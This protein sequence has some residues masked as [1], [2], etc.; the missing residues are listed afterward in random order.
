M[1]SR[2]REASELLEISGLSKR[3]GRQIVL[4]GVELRI[5]H[6]E[7][8]AVMGPS[9]SG[10]ST[11]LTCLAGLEEPDAGTI[12]FMGENLSELSEEQRA[13][14]RRASITS[15]FQFFHLLPTLRAAE[16]VEFPLLL[17]GDEPG[18]RRQ[19]VHSLLEEIGLMERA[20]AWPSE[21]SGGEMQR[22]A[23]ARALVTEPAIILA[24]EPTGSLDSKNSD[25]VLELLKRLT[26]A[27]QTA[28]L[29]VTHDKNAANICERIFE[30]R[31]GQLYPLVDEAL[32][33]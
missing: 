24:D 4:S 25:R 15:I 29:M 13:A 32:T 30:M 17:R 9:G 2:R 26:S 8:V 31:D 23:I 16:N 1:E 10:K 20:H 22:L 18:A 11:L 27:H 28:L 12:R 19:R 6:G 7:R 21:L 5:G 33:Q 14:L 3:F